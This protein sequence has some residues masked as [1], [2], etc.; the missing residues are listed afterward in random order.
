V[1]KTLNRLTTPGGS[2]GLDKSKLLAQ[3]SRAA[4]TYKSASSLQQT[5]AAD[6]VDRLNLIGLI[7]TIA[8]DLGSATG[9]VGELL[10]ALVPAVTVINTDFSKQMASST[11]KIDGE[12]Y[13][14]VTT[15][16]KLAFADESIPLV[17]SNMLLHWC[18]VDDVLPEVCRILELDGIFLFSTLGP[19]TLHELRHF[20]EQV[21]D[22]PH[23]HEFIDIRDLGDA[24]IRA[25]FSEPVLDVD[26]CV[27][28]HKDVAQLVAELRGT[29]GTNAR[30]D[31]RRSCTGRNRYRQFVDAYEQIADNDGIPS[32]WEV[33]YGLATKHEA[34]VKKG[35]AVA[36]PGNT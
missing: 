23:V 30:Y 21:D 34:V 12:I 35:L 18:D 28:K 7:P 16:E 25:G 2:Y 36:I 8:L 24:L 15:A 26:R 17:I 29:G 5:T 19:G 10:R 27:R 22:S 20:W 11:P 1:D 4:E 9:H 13:D 32:T 14:V 6:L 33:I 3:F 31:R